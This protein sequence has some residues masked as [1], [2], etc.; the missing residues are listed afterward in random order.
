MKQIVFTFDDGLE[1]HFSRV[2][3]FFLEHGLNATFYVT[4][5]RHM[6]RQHRGKNLTEDGLAEPQITWIHKQG[7]EIGNHTLNH[8]CSP[9]VEREVVGME[10]Y[11]SN[12]D[13][14][15]PETFCFPGYRY[16]GVKHVEESE[17]LLKSLGYKCARTGYNLHGIKQLHEVPHLREI[18]HHFPGNFIVYSTMVMN[19]SYTFENFKK[20]LDDDRPEGAIPIVTAH[21]LVSDSRWDSMKKAALY[22]KEQ[23]FQCVAMR[24]INPENTDEAD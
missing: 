2:A 15:K 16:P 17:R 11:L 5:R 1:S 3:P 7:F 6:W 19:D 4:G 18:I 12:L 10:M 8:S 14:P 9:L 24:D 21:G 22:A 23:G 20:D 13:V